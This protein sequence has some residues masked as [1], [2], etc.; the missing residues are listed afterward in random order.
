M[1][2]KEFSC[3]ILY[4][5]EALRGVDSFR[6]EKGQFQED[7]LVP[8]RMLLRRWSTLLRWTVGEQEIVVWYT[9]SRPHHLPEYLVRVSPGPDA[10]GGP[11]ASTGNPFKHPGITDCC[12]TFILQGRRGY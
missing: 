7:F 10:T 3:S 4:C 2:H 1:T 11:P 6:L 5:E 12:F 8:T 9:S